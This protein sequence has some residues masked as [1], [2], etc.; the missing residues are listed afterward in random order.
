MVEFQPS[1]LVMRVRFPSSAP[2]GAFTKCPGYFKHLL[3]IISSIWR[4]VR[5]WFNELVLKTSEGKTS[6]GSNPSLSS[7]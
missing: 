1:K 4:G 3:L 2:Q 5:A 7:N 6:E